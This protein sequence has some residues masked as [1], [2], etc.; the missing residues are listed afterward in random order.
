M[1]P[2]KPL[3][4]PLCWRLNLHRKTSKGPQRAFCIHGTKIQVTIWIWQENGN[5]NLC[6]S[7]P[8]S[9]TKQKKKKA[10]LYIPSGSL[11]P[12]P[13]Q[14][15]YNLP[16]VNVPCGL[17]FNVTHMLLLRTGTVYLKWLKY[18]VVSKLS[19]LF[20]FSQITL[21]NIFLYWWKWPSNSSMHTTLLM[22]CDCEIC[23][24]GCI[25]IRLGSD[26]GNFP[27]IRPGPSE[28]STTGT[29]R[30]GEVHEL[31]Q[32]YLWF[33]KRSSWIETLEECCSFALF[34]LGTTLQ[35]FGLMQ[36]SRSL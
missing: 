16:V 14:N 11:Y 28:S 6:E 9:S 21:Y 20:H 17:C 34:F 35:L 24:V 2:G 18:C 5:G 32:S 29:E 10:L 33:Q 27:A 31:R 26:A 4:A 23:C 30:L 15:L 12:F 19:L 7:C 8:T 22:T 13:K 36:S 1:T 25:C 3:I